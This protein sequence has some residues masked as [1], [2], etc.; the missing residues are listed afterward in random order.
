[1]KPGRASLAEA[2][3]LITDRP[4]RAL[5]LPAGTLDRGA[6]ADFALF[7]PEEQWVVQRHGFQSKSNNSPFIGRTLHGKVKYTVVDGEP[8]T[9]RL[10]TAQGR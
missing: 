3:S 8:V 9:L 7:D 10:R 5:G 6:A 4:A 2:V 1:V